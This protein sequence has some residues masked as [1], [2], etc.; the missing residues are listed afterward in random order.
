LASSH[1]PSGHD[2][3]NPAPAP[4]EEEVAASP[5]GWLRRNGPIL[6]VVLAL[7]LSLHFY[8]EMEFDTWRRIL[9]TA[10]GLGFVIFVHELGH[11]LVA[12]WCDVHVETFSIGF[13]PPLPGCCFRRGET[14]YMI[15]LFPLGG[16][17]K[18]VGEGA[19]SDESDND[20]RSFKN[21]PVWQRMAIISAGVTMNM[22]LAFACFVFVFR[23]H[24]D[25][26][27]PS[28]VGQV[29]P[30]SP[31]WKKGAKTGDVIHWVGNKGPNPSFTDELTPT[32]M[33]SREGEKLRFEFGPPNASE[34]QIVKTEIEPRKEE[35]DLRPM[36]G[37]SP[38]N[39]LKLVAPRLRKKQ[40][41][42]YRITSAAAQA[43]PAFQF[44]DVIVAS[45]F[46]PQHPEAIK[47]LPPDPRDPAH[48]DFFEFGK[49]MRD[50][51]GKPVRIQVLRKGTGESEVIDVPPAYAYTLGLRM[52]M[53][54]IVAIRD[55]S[56]AAA[57]GVQPGDAIENVEVTT[58][59]GRVRYVSVRTNTK[60]VV[61][62]DLDPVRLP[63]EL[64]QWAASKVTPKEVHLTVSRD[65]PPNPQHEGRKHVDLTLRWDDGWKY[66]HEEVIRPSSPLS[67]PGLGIA[68]RVETT[69]A[70][71][72]PDSPAQKAGFKA[73][74]VI[75]EWRPLVSGK[76]PGTEPKPGDW[77]PIQ[78]NQWAFL[79]SFFQDYDYKQVAF[80]VERPV[81]D[82]S[83]MTELTV[84]AVE[85]K[86]WP[87]D[88]RG[89]F[90]M[91]DERIVKADTLGEAL[92]LGI[93]KTKNFIDQILG[94]LRSIATGRVSLKVFGGPIMIAQAGFQF[95]ENIYRFLVFLG[96]IGVNLAV[97]NFL[98]IP[99]LDGG[100]MVFLIY[101]KLRGKPAPERLRVAAT[102]VGVALILVL[103]VFIT[104][105][106]ILRNL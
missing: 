12:K 46:D 98:P 83:E 99:V 49:R 26:R 35:N 41:V 47:E 58:G 65:L 101:E 61:E 32:V 31:A 103:M 80:R 76:K 19:E 14:T 28:V 86:T 9:I 95:A 7:F 3:I 54:K 62:K 75:K 22:L 79:F 10:L 74:D 20:P 57:A 90:F 23:T 63:F 97:V 16:Y 34:D 43:K 37:I 39:Q 2:E 56:P 50:L 93:L 53:G 27:I 30:G 104:Y 87:M 59:E 48:R 4:S 1:E 102:L 94:N 25:E 18:M 91:P 84:T 29:E 21:K 33:N 85:D 96:I 92:S 38:P 69:V 89:L 88:D 24:G 60:D 82:K 52:R 5:R 68:F 72:E 42:P 36:I 17:V 70:G 67:I 64:E 44:G 55:G 81:A 78:Q 40:G 100:H 66:D 15:A 77:T 106:D 8:F 71:V 105:Q 13:G 73:D 45:S 11:F 51:A 6:F